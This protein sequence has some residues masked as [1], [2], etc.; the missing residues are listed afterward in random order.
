MPAGDWINTGIGVIAA[1]ALAVS[2]VAAV[3]AK[4]AKQAARDQANTEAEA[5][6]DSRRPDFDVHVEYMTPSEWQRLRFTL[7]TN[8]DLASGEVWIR[9]PKGGELRFSAGQEGY[10]PDS[11]ESPMHSTHG[12]LHPGQSFCRRVE[13]D[14]A[15]R[16]KALRVEFRSVGA[17][18]QRWSRTKTVEIPED[19]AVVA[20]RETMRA[21]FERANRL[22]ERRK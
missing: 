5:L 9:E 11:T 12:G 4:H 18:G 22:Y 3:V 8:Y 7:A 19:P 16:P 2:I 14:V 17:G 13:F 6:N 1:A 15:N 21:L 20:Q 10:D